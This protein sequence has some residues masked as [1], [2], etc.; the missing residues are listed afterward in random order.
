[1]WGTRDSFLGGVGFG[2]EEM[3]DYSWWEAQV[4]Q[5]TGRSCSL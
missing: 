5:E 1:M 2:R 4:R 3:T